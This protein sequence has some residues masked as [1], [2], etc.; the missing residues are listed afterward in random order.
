MQRRA[1]VVAI[2][3]LLGATLFWAGNYVVGGAAVADME[4]SS[5][6]LL[7]WLFA[8]IPLLLIAQFVEQPNWRLVLRAWPWLLSLA[9][10]GL[11]AYTLLLYSALKHTDALN[12][13]LINAFN[14]ALITLGAALF[15]R[16][17]L[18]IT[19]VIGTLIAFLG[20]LVVL[21]RGHLAAIADG[22]F[23][24]G[25][26]LMIA[27]IIAWTGYTIIG[28]L[29][30]HLPPL[31]FTA[32]Q[33]ALATV[34]M[35]VTCTIRGGLDLPSST[36]STAALVYIVV[37]PS[38]LSYLLWNH[39]LRTIS[40]SSAGVFLNLIT[41]YTALMTIALGRPIELAQIIGGCI[42]LGGVAVTNASRRQRQ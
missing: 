33:A 4:P 41:V 15:L 38:V 1:P 10:L 36:Q 13:S 3:S 21:T 29:A 23:G 17:R 18:T 2:L 22:G 31:S 19:S 27:A 7:R 9:L 35:A 40:A 11:L 42:V 28:R 14:P 26:I 32:A 5:L 16:E 8:A 37:F 25:D 20:V 6:V 30:P 34:V 39:A 24:L 12:A